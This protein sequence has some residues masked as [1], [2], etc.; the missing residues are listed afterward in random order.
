M[1]K[2][3][4]KHGQPG[5][6]FARD[7]FRKHELPGAEVLSDLESLAEH[8]M[9]VDPSTYAASLRPVTV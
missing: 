2:W 7:M 9:P 5:L 3:D 8:S 6:T 4:L 1:V